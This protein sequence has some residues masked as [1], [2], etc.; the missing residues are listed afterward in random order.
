[1]FLVSVQASYIQRKHFQTISK[2]KTHKEEHFNVRPRTVRA[3]C[4]TGVLYRPLNAA[5]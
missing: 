5:R 1:M 4:Y 2:T 3:L